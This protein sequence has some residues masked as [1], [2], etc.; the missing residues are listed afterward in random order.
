M[1]TIWITARTYE[2]IA[3]RAPNPSLS[4]K[5]GR[6]YPLTL[7]RGTIN[8]LRTAREPFE[9]MDDVVLRIAN[10]EAFHSLKGPQR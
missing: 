3:G 8:C 4:D 10:G 1:V 6:G 9:S 7:E 2:A 5:R